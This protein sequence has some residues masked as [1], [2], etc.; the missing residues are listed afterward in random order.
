MKISLLLFAITTSLMLFSSNVFAKKP[1]KCPVFNDKDLLELDDFPETPVYQWWRDNNGTEDIN[2]RVDNNTPDNRGIT[3]DL[4]V[5][6]IKSF[7]PQSFNLG[8]ATYDR[9]QHKEHPKNGRVS[10]R[11]TLDTELLPPLD[12]TTGPILDVCRHLLIDKICN[13]PEGASYVRSLRTGGGDC[14][15]TE[16]GV[17]CDVAC[18]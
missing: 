8:W 7:N 14:L 2:I 9:K 5:Q 13:S 15:T 4:K 17:T 12:P 6:T 3:V 10:D 11:D 18:P 16:T 1:I